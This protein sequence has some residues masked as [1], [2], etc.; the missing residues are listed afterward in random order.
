[1]EA[2]IVSLLKVQYNDGLIT[3]EFIKF[4]LKINEKNSEVYKQLNEF[5][6]QIKEKRII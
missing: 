6:E 4:M 5:Y 1:M 3:K 2:L